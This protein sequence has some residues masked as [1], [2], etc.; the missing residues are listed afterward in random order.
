[1]AYMGAVPYMGA[2]EKL[3]MKMGFL[4]FL[5]LPFVKRRAYNSVPT[6]SHI[7]RVQGGSFLKAPL[8]A[9]FTSTKKCTLSVL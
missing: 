7:H 2:V 3:L 8:V 9:E 4:L 1:M 5:Y 6:R